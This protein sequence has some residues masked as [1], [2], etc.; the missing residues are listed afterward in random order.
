[1]TN[2]SG[3]S[4]TDNL[5]NNTSVTLTLGN[6]DSDAA[7]VEVFNGEDSLGTATQVAGV[8]TLTTEVGDLDEGG[9]D[10][11]VTVTDTAGNSNSSTILDV[12]LDTSASATIRIN[13]IGDDG[14]LNASELVGDLLGNVAITGS[15]GGDASEGDTVT[16]S[17]T[18]NDGTTA[19]YTGLVSDSDTYS[20]GIP[21]AVLSVLTDTTISASVSGTDAAGNIFTAI[22]DA[23]DGGFT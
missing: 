16:L 9:N 3:D 20:I 23:T 13:A 12:T 7:S 4:D 22:S 21:S 6:I 5:T 2:D 19:S 18:L 1:M 17:V 15:V 10:L 8:W 11:T 14:I